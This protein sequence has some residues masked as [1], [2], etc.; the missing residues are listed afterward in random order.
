MIHSGALMVIVDGLNEVSADTREKIGTFARDMSK[1][2]VLIGTQPIEWVPPPGARII[3]LLPLDREEAERFLLSR[4]VGAD[5]TQ[6]VHGMPMPIQSTLF[7]AARST[8]HPARK[9]AG[10]QGSSCRTHSTLPLRQTSWR[11]D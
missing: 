6:K 10:R 1:G 5:M 8:R 4:P 11:R 3:D 9:I 2:D 7:C